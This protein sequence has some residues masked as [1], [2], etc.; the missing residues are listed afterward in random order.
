[1]LHGLKRLG[2]ESYADMLR[3]IARETPAALRAIATLPPDAVEKGYVLVVKPGRQFFMAGRRG[4]SALIWRPSAT[5]SG[6][7]ISSGARRPTDPCCSAL[8]HQ[9][10]PPRR[11]ADA[12]DGAG[13]GATT[14]LLLLCRRDDASSSRAAFRWPSPSPPFSEDS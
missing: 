3:R 13:A 12:M 9:H 7:L 5:S 14:S 1:M 6:L 11:R 10:R 2:G 8:P 4:A